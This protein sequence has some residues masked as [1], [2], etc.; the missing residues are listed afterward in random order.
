MTFIPWND[1]EVTVL[2]LQMLPQHLPAQFDAPALAGG[3][4]TAHVGGP[5]HRLSVTVVTEQLR[6]GKQADI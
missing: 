6:A 3:G 5:Q 2:R 1:I 4:G